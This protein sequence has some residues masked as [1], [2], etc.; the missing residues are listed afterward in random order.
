MFVCCFSSVA[1]LLSW[2]RIIP[3]YTRCSVTAQSFHA[4]ARYGEN[5]LWLVI[6]NSNSFP[7]MVNRTHV[8]FQ[9]MS[10]DWSEFFKN[11]SFYGHINPTWGLQ[12]IN[13][14]WL[15]R[16]I[17]NLC[18]YMARLTPFVFN[19]LATHARKPQL[20]MNKIGK[21]FIYYEKFINR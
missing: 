18:P 1:F 16:I 17:S 20:K 13:S 8:G 10:Y 3:E 14:L 5:A 21:I 12:I 15:V 9:I 2:T 7:F 4:R 6:L 19:R 11:V